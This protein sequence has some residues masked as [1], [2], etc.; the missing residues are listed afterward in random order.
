MEFV[1]IEQSSQS[2]RFEALDALA[3]MAFASR[4]GPNGQSTDELV[5]LRPPAFYPEPVGR[6]SVA[7]GATRG[8]FQGGLVV[9]EGEATFPSLEAIREFVR[10]GYVRGSAGDGGPANPEGGEPLPDPQGSPNIRWDQERLEESDDLEHLI[11]DLKHFHVATTNCR[12]GE[13]IPLKWK[14]VGSVRSFKAGDDVL[15]K[16]AVV[17]LAD[18]YEHGV[19]ADEYE[20]LVPTITVVLLQLGIDINDVENSVAERVEN[21]YKNGWHELLYAPYNLSHWPNWW[22]GQYDP[23][24]FLDR[25]K[26]PFRGNRSQEPTSLLAWLAQF[27]STPLTVMDGS[28]VRE[29]CERA[30]FTAAVIIMQLG[31]GIPL[32]SKLKLRQRQEVS[33][34]AF[35]WLREHLPRV[36]FSLQYEQAIGTIAR[37]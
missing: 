36:G 19:G 32:D 24:D 34:A 6:S 26:G 35:T 2:W 1:S 29:C 16:G 15:T 4:I 14:S 8:S 20:S 31:Y 3:G 21:F 11:D 28:M 10:R 25:M 5:F 22:G 33:R 9:G 18:L 37:R 7:L 13:A 12:P 27:L 23:F 30:V 17:A